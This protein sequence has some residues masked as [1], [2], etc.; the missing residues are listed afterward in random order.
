MT[1]DQFSQYVKENDTGRIEKWNFKLFNISCNKCMSNNIC[2][3][4][5][6]FYEYILVKCIGCGNTFKIK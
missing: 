5:H 4:I 1:V 2:I 3:Y 6:E